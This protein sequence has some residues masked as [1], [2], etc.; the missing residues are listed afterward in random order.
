MQ[1]EQ[2]LDFH[3]VHPLH[4]VIHDRLNNWRRYVRM[5]GMTLGV[6]PMFRGYRPERDNGH[7]LEPHIPID[8]LDGHVMEKAV[9]RLPEKNRD[10]IRWAYVYSYVPD[11]KIRKHLGVTR[12]GLVTLIHDAR[13]M[14]KN[15]SGI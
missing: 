1:R 5:G 14:L 9:Y 11:P 12:A 8:E 15:R 7:D 3:S 4:L 10:A 2:Q 6:S 13:S